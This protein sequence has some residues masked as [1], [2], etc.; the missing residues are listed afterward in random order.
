LLWAKLMVNGDQI[1]II[2][3]QRV[4]PLHVNH[5]TPAKYRWSVRING[6]TYSPPPGE[7]IEHQRSEGAIAL[8]RKV[9]DRVP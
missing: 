8:I 7:L 1:G 4:E 9:L 2:E 3:I 5:S 6:N